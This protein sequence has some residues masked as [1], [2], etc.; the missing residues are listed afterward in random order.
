MVRG[1]QALVDSSWKMS[2][3]ILAV[4]WSVS[5]Y[6]GDTPGMEG[7]YGLGHRAWYFGILRNGMKAC[8]MKQMRRWWLRPRPNMSTTFV[9][10]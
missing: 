9:G 8:E 7:I 1:Y 3:G 4:N 5:F 10:Q 6:G 2:C